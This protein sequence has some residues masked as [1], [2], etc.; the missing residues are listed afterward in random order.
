M[1]HFQFR[2]LGEDGNLIDN[3]FKPKVRPATRKITNGIDIFESITD[4]ANW[5]VENEIS[6]AKSKMSIA[7]NI[8]QCCR[9]SGRLK[10]V[11]GFEWSYAQ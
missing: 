9:K 7:A 6:K 5:V 2:Y 11:F 10:T 1:T 3:G 4:A 8:C